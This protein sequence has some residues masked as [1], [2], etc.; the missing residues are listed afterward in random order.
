[1]AIFTIRNKSTYVSKVNFTDLILERISTSIQVS[2]ANNL[3]SVRLVKNAT[4]GGTPSYTD[5]NTSD[6]IV[7]FDVAATTVTGGKDLFNIDLAGKNDKE[8]ENLVP[9]KIIIAPGD[10]VTFAGT[11]VSSATIKGSLLWKELF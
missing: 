10:T 6:S 9:Y 1:V 8:A 7:D 4:L 11:S 5:I 3:G 2:S